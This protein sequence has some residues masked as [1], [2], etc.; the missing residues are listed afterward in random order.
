MPIQSVSSITFNEPY[1]QFQN[2][3]MS[4]TSSKISVN[5]ESS[6]SIVD[7]VALS[8]VHRP[9][10]VKFKE[11]ENEVKLKPIW[12]PS[13]ELESDAPQYKPIKPNLTP[14]GRSSTYSVGASPIPLNE[15]PLKFTSTS[16]QFHERDYHVLKPKPLAAFPIHQVKPSYEYPT[17]YYTA[18]AGP[19][20]HNQKNVSSES[21]RHMEMRES[22]ECSEHI[23]NMSST[24]RIAQ[25]DQNQQQQHHERQEHHY[26][27][28][29]NDPLERQL[30][31]FPF[32]VSPNVSSIRHKF[33]P[34][35][36]TPIKFKPGDCRESDYDSEVE[37]FRIRS[38]WTPNQTESES[39][40]FRHVSAPT[41]NRCAS[42]TKHNS[43]QRILTPMDFDSGIVEMP[44][45][46]QTMST[47][48]SCFSSSPN[49][50][51]TQTLDRFRSKKK[52]SSHLKATSQDDL[53][54]VHSTTKYNRLQ[55]PSLAFNEQNKST[56][57]GK[58]SLHLYLS[59]IY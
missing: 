2:Q 24:K 52:S 20:Y 7:G 54:I 44:T 6:Y 46:I 35:P 5:A 42:A 40:P 23:V 17:Q 32:K 15:K 1:F 14:T 53:S 48:S 37:S 34:P 18:T 26:Q 27:C 36:P 55:S 31:A 25:Y 33:I 47:P 49:Q 11:I 13:Y 58:C 29:Q 10:S 59:V 21:S 22:T 43:F 9:S 57:Y 56:E 3:F 12:R 50:F 51:K 41:P 19:P 38:V 45:K 30:E 4:S 28:H 16:E 8:P 39:K